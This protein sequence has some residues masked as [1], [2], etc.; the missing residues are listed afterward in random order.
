MGFTQAQEAPNTG[1]RLW[2]NHRTTGALL[3]A[4]AQIGA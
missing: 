2:H 4:L 1:I 3:E